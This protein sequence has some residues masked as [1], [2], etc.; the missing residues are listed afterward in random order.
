MK[1]I[2]FLFALLFCASANAQTDY[3]RADAFVAAFNE[4]YSDAADLA[5]KLTTTFQTEEEKARVLFM[6]LANNVRYDCKKFTNPPNHSVSARSK[7]ELL[8]KRREMEEK[9]LA[10]SFKAKKGICADYSNIY[11]AMCD[12][13][14]LEAVVIIG[15]ARDFYRPYRNA[16]NNSHAWNAVK[17]DGQWRLLDATWAAGYVN[18]E[19]TKFTQ[20]LFPGYFLTDPKWFIQNH[21]P[22]DDKWQ[23]LEQPIGKKQFPDQPLINYG[24][25]DYPLLDFSV[26]PQKSAD[27]KGYEIRFKFATT[28]KA[29]LMT[30]NNARPMDFETRQED[31]WVVLSFT[32]KPREITVFAGESQRQHMGWLARYEVK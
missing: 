18:P 11:K 2:L 30:S 26:A 9:E 12:A 16:Q 14:G 20:R 17:I 25:Q 28:P 3:S 5:K 6:W 24:Q 8:Q 19:V 15:D 27:D 31:G 10:K 21:F 1:P 13:V 23:L 7:E 29:F 32:K 22:D 4:P